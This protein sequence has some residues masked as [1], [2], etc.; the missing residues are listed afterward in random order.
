MK[1]YITQ[2]DTSVKL[3]Y[4]CNSKADIIINKKYYCAVCELNRKGY[5]IYE[6]KRVR[7]KDRNT[8][9]PQ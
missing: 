5:K 2:I 9:K 1:K 3:C 8:I 7:K 6:T 4:N